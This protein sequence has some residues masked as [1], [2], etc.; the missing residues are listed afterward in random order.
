[1][2]LAALIFDV[3][4]TLAETEEVH[5][6]AF[7][8]VFA[9]E[10]LGW[11]WDRSLYRRLLAVS[12]GRERMRAYAAE[13]A[14]ERLDAGFDGLA[15]RMHE[16]KTAIYTARVAAGAVPL[17]PGVAAILREARSAG[18][19]CAVATTTSRANVIA[20]LE[21]ATGGEGHGW[22]ETLVCAEDAP[23]KKPAPDVYHEALRRLGLPA[24]AALAFEDST[25]GLAATRAAA[26]PVVITEGVYTAGDDFTGALAVLP[27]LA[28]FDLAAARRLHRQA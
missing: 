21:G 3:D 13:A 16:R 9:E 12:G 2:D 8:T 23:I 4:G 14:P 5:R 7:N 25:N 18:L 26:I 27:D 28:G 11:H 15:A 6:D 10:G 22:F 17:R 1:M 19:R 24:A 20:L